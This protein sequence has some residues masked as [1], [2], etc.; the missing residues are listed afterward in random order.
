MNHQ[1][2]LI[3]IIVEEE[4]STNRLNK[5]FFH[6]YDFNKEYLI[7]LYNVTISNIYK[8]ERYITCMPPNVL[9]NSQDESTCYVN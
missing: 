8:E 9:I 2:G 4:E 1:D 5:W 3:S 7:L 6:I